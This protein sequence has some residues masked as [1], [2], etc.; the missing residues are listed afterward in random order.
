MHVFKSLG[1]TFSYKVLL[2]NIFQKVKWVFLKNAFL[3]QNTK[4][5]IEIYI[6]W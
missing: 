4:V 2:R 3:Y 1:I 6:K 5:K